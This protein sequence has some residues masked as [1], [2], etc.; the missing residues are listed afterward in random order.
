VITIGIETSCD[1]TAVTLIENNGKILSNVL[2]SQDAFHKDFGGIVPEIASRKH[3][4][5]IGYTIVEAL[6]L[7]NLYLNSI[8]LISVTK[9]PGLVGSLLVGVAF[10]YDFSCGHALTNAFG[11]VHIAIYDYFNF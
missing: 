9:G 11:F 1:D 5:L 4:E 2:T 6:K 8:D 7:A 3:A 10:N